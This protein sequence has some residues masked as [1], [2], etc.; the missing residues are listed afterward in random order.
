MSA[1]LEVNNLKIY[2]YTPSGVVR[3]VD[4]VDFY[5]RRNESLCVVGE[6]GSGKSTLAMG[7]AGL[8][9]PPGRVVDGEARFKN[10]L[11]V[12]KNSSNVQ[13]YLGKQITLIFQDPR[14]ALNPVV[15]IGDQITEAIMHN[16]NLDH[17][18]AYKIAYELLKKVEIP[19]PERVLNSYP[20]ELSGGMAQRVVI[21]TAVSTNPE[22]I[23]ADEPTSALDVTIQ[24]QILKLLKHIVKSQGT[25]LIF[26]THDLSVALEICDRTIIMYAGKI[27]EEGDTKEIFEKPLHPY[28]TALLSSIPKIGFKTH[29][30][31]NIPGEP[32]QMTNPPKG[33]RFHPRCPFKFDLCDKLEPSLINVSNSRRV[34]CLLFSSHR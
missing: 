7:I 25:S 30:L 6:S 1:I 29:K 3:A 31:P 28:T 21:A 23:I 12:S 33:C 13:K 2:Y 4:G 15:K 16:L 10:E 19:D 14:S 11:V 9:D 17:E 5:L 24:S 26:I 18:R 27:V 34:A 22:L 32:P 8:I 20:H